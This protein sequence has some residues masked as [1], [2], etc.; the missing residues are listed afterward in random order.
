M[1]RV[2]VGTLF[3]LLVLAST[4]GGCEDR[5]FRGDGISQR[6][7]ACAQ[8]TSCDTCTPV[9]G[10]GWCFHGNGGGSCVADPDQCGGQ[11]FS[12]TWE[13]NGCRV[14]ADASTIEIDAGH[15]DATSDSASDA[16]HDGASDASSDGASDR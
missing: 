9:V 4:L 3:A 7:S 8:M 12:W 2:A 10:C 1:K 13:P 15:G 11:Q 5:G 14:G 16:P 6:A